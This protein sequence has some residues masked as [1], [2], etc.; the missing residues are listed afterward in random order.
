MHTHEH[1]ENLAEAIFHDIFLHGI[2]DTLKLALFLFAAYLLMEFLEHKASDK[3][4]AFLKRSGKLGPLVGGALGAIP[5]CGFSSV[6]A[7]LFCGKVI[8]LGTLIAVFLSTSDEMLPIMLSGIGDR[9]SAAKIL[10]IL[11]YKILVGV[12]VGFAVDLVVKLASLGHSHDDGHGHIHEIC[13]AEGCNC[14]GGIFRSAIKHTL[15][16]SLFILVITVAINAILFFLGEEKL[17]M[18]LPDIPVVS[19]LIC[20]LIGLIPNCASSVAL[21]EFYM[22]EIIT[23]GEM[24]S[25]LFA[26]SGVGLLILFRVNKKNIK[27]NLVILAILIASGTLFGVLGDALLFESL[28]Q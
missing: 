18:L 5:Q 4:S 8:S 9:L 14:E 3:T 12:A 27:E 21:T 13:E 7:N 24:L 10:F 20:T 23:L 6:S 17:S 25:G 28:F 26:G 19:H 16:T 11:G 15:T 1:S 2:L 22:S